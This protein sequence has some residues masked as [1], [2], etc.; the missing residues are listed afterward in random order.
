MNK[1]RRDAI[2]ISSCA[3]FSWVRISS[4]FKVVF[5]AGISLACAGI[6]YLGDVIGYCLD[7]MIKMRRDLIKIRS[8]GGGGG[9]KT[10]EMWWW[11]W[12]WWRENNRN[13]VVVEEGK[14]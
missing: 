1:M 5:C 8:C 3:I 6:N 4:Y 10:I 11:W 2:N 14:Q 7:V 12:W 9:G 13:V